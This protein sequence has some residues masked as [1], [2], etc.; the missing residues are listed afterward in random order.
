MNMYKL[1]NKNI[2]KTKYDEKFNTCFWSFFAQLHEFEVNTFN[3]YL[4]TELV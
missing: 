4:L 1:K 2:K 3:I